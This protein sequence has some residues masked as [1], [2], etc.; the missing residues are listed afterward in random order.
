MTVLL[1]ILVYLILINIIAS[2][3]AISDKKKAQ[4][5][6]WRIPESSLMLIGLFGGAFGEYITMKKIHHKTKHA[7]FMIGLPLEIF[8]HIIIIALII[9][10]VAFIK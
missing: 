6:K 5:G 2:I 10:K 8:V 1:V 7:K 4:K 3:M 9:Y